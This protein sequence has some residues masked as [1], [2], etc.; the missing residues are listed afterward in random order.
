MHSTCLLN[1]SADNNKA[2]FSAGTR[3]ISHVES[4]MG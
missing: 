2:K 3:V 4:E 1:M